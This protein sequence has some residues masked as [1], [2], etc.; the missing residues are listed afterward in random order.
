MVKEDIG[1]LFGRRVSF[2]GGSILR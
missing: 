1:A 2:L